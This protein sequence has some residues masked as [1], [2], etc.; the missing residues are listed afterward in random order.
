M[1][2]CLIE[3]VPKK[4][5]ERAEENKFSSR[6]NYFFLGTLVFAAF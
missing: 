2:I 5:D 4:K 1:S 6:G 3:N